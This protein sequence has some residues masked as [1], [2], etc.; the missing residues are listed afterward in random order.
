V[1]RLLL[2]GDGGHAKVVRDIALAGGQYELAAVLDD[3]YA[4]PA[5]GADGLPRGPVALAARML[6]EDEDLRVFVAI[7]SGTV[8][9]KVAGSLGIE[10]DRFA[11]LI[12]PRAV[13]SGDASL[14]PGTAVMPGA[15]VNAGARIGA[16]AIVNTGAVVEHDCV[17]GDYAHVSPN[18]ALAGGVDVGAGA[19]IGIGASVIQGLTVGE[20]STLGA[21][22]VAVRDIPAGCTAAGV[23]ARVIRQ[24]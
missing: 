10:P 11:L 15:V 2:I 14:A 22:A 6:A 20:W 7:G 16:H 18:A 13:V 17:I 5:A 3:R 1:R 21:G 24:A 4:D 23:P 12:H 8:R 19:H 9:R